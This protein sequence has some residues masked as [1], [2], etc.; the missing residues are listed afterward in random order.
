LQ[1]VLSCWE[2]LFIG[3]G[4]FGNLILLNARIPHNRDM[5]TYRLYAKASLRGIAG[6]LPL[7]READYPDDGEAR[8]A[9]WP[10][11]MKLFSDAYA[12]SVS[13]RKDLNGVEA[14]VL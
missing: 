14:V 11:I 4:L 1:I 13:I 2:S 8:A 12:V 10:E 6:E 5:T 9:F 7:L 3:I